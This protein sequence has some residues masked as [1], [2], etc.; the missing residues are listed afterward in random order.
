MIKKLISTVLATMLLCSTTASAMAAGFQVSTDKNVVNAGE[1]VTVT[2]NLDKELAGNFRN[3]QGQ[4]VYDT[5]RLTYVSHKM[6]SPYQH[7][8][9]KD[10]PARKYF[11]FSNTDTSAAGFSSMPKGNVVTVV[12]QTSQSMTGAHATAAFTLT[13]SV[14]DTAGHSEK[15]TS[16]A[17][18]VVCKTH[19][20]DN[21]KVTTEPGCTSK[22]VRTYA[23]T[24]EGCGAEK[25]ESIDAVGHAYG[26]GYI[27]GTCGNVNEALKPTPDQ[28]TTPDPEQG[29]T[30]NPDSGTTTPDPG[31]TPN[32]DTSTTTPEQGTTRPEPDTTPDTDVTPESGTTPDPNPDVT[33]NPEPDADTTTPD[34]DATPD[35][36]TTTPDPGTTPNPTPNTDPE[37][38][39]PAACAHTWNDADCTSPK[40][41]S[42]CGET[43]GD[44]LGHEAGTA[45]VTRKA[46]AS[47][48]GAKVQKCTRCGQTMKTMQIKSAKVSLSKA[49]YTY[50]GKK[51]SSKKLPKIVVKDGNGKTISAK[52]Y[53]VKKPSNVKKMK[54]IGRYSY[55]V[56]FKKSCKEYTGTKTVYLE[57]KPAK[58]SLTSAKGAKKAVTV[59][60]KKGKKA[61]VT[62]YEVLLA[63]DKKFSKNKKTITV[64]G[65]AKTSKKI[66]KLKAKKTYYA[67][68]RTYK[69]VKGV[70]IYSD[71]SKV[72]TVKTK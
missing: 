65:F 4:L 28:G 37:P 32:P 19:T 30:P 46:T 59:K 10:M 17:S 1:T 49:A 43:E 7:Y 44:A 5:S 41:C 40:T 38:E 31:T 58:T 60:W 69:T 47:K 26:N 25:T 55:K 23:C 22:G 39:A 29:E 62:G 63:T 20:W 35:S 64:K 15:T 11:T 18:L 13:M 27:C 8:M 12:F 42:T 54:N 14:Q 53:T 67:K 61:Q 6:S 70:K 34:A 66:T 2:V 57:I 9:A 72:K 71:W 48:A 45:A 36:G 68:V 52:Y 24:Y 3:V 21:G 33:P 56:T 16:A 50:T 51:I